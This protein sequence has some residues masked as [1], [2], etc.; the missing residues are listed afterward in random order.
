MA[1]QQLLRTRLDAI[2]TKIAEHPRSERSV[3]RAR[4]IV[5]KHGKAISAAITRELQ[6]HQLPSL[7]RL[8]RISVASAL[9]WGSLHRQR[10][11]V[12]RRMGVLK[13]NG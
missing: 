5:T 11:S 1:N 7:A 10:R 8:T 3:V 13:F 6:E 9:T 2:D 12:L 4:A